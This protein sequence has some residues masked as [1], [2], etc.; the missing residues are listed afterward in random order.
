MIV[1]AFVLIAPG[2]VHAGTAETYQQY[3]GECHGADRL[4]AMGPALL[5]EN[6]GR[7]RK[8]KAAKT[9]AD[10]RPAI[11]M[12]AFGE[13]LNEAQIKGL[14]DMI[15]TPLPKMPTWTVADMNASHIM[16]NDPAGLPKTPAT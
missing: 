5:P 3:C 11:Q 1:A 8:D 4:G 15:Y 13:I 7:L 2:Q 6:L 12:P 9:I 10:G 16:H 14:V